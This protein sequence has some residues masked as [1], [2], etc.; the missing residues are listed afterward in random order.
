[1][2]LLG[3]ELNK[4]LYDCFRV[5]PYTHPI[6]PASE[7]QCRAESQQQQHQQ[8]CWEC[9]K[10]QGQQEGCQEEA[11]KSGYW[12]TIQL[13]VCHLSLVLSDSF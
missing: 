8:Q 11:N 13:C 2:T 1:M 3:K 12:H 9:E 5:K 7:C 6:I 10:E 4:L